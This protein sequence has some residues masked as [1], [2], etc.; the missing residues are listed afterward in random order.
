MAYGNWGAFV[1][2]D[3]ARSRAH[4]DAEAF[5]GT[6]IGMGGTLHAVLGDGRVRLGGW[7]HHPVLVVD[8]AEVDL[9]PYAVPPQDD[10]DRLDGDGDYEGS[11]HGFLFTAAMYE[12]RM[13]DLGLAEPDGTVWTAT[14]GFEYGA[15]W[16]DD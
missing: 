5:P 6:D 11:V 14:C 12:G 10:R 8:G 1:R 16:M 13:V 9:S 4:E 7:K 2:K 3:G 15:G